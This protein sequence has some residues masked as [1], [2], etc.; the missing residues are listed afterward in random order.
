MKESGPGAIHRTLSLPVANHT[1][2][3]IQS[4][5]DLNGVDNYLLHSF[6]FH[7]F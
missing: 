2:D 7:I 1:L 4:S 3:W 5:Q 6:A